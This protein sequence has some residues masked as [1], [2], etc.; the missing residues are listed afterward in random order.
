MFIRLTRCETTWPRKY[1][2]YHQEIAPP[3]RRCDAATVIRI[4][5][6]GIVYGT[7]T[8]TVEDEYEA[9]IAALNA[10]TIT[11]LD[12]D[13]RILPNFLKDHRHG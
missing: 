13:G 10:R 11:P 5:R 8:T 4:G 1:Y 9:M 6:R 7:W 3:F 2:T 12:N